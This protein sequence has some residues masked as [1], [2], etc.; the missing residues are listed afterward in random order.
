[1]SVSCFWHGFYLHYYFC[2]AYFILILEI[3]KDIYR[4]WILFESIPRPIRLFTAWLMTRISM[5]YIGV[6]FKMGGFENF[7]HFG[8][9]TNYFILWILPLLFVGIK[10][11]GVVRYA[12]KLEKARRARPSA[13]RSASRA[14]R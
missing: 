8:K 6:C 3:S 4:S 9:G 11:S 7:Y 13:S 12:K 2:F 1:M 10:T 14:S 5:G